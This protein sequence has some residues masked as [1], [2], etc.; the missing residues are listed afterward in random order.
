MIYGHKLKAIQ[1]AL[2]MFGFM[3]IHQHYAVNI[4]KTVPFL[5]IQT[6]VREDLLEDI[7]QRLKFVE[8]YAEEKL[9][10]ENK[11]EALSRRPAED[12]HETRKRF[13]GNE[14]QAQHI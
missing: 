14:H 11:D 10:K 6:F 12:R 3:E 8:N 4:F 7:H 2:M 13:R 5:S 9:K 1:Q